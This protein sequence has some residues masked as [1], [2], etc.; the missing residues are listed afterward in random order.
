[1][2]TRFVA[3]ILIVA[4]PCIWPCLSNLGDG[5]APH[6]N[7][8]LSGGGGFARRALRYGYLASHRP[9]LVKEGGFGDGHIR[10][11]GEA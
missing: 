6:L 2:V 8:F 4:V 9:S 1:M 7:I 11:I 3:F 5:P 10:Q